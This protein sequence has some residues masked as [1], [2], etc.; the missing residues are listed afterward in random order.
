MTGAPSAPTSVR[1]ALRAGQRVGPYTIGHPLGEG[2]SGIVYRAERADGSPSPVAL[3]VIHRHLVRDPQV[4]RRFHR[5]AQILGQLRGPNLAALLDTGEAEDGRLYMALELVEGEPLDV[6]TRQGPLPIEQAVDIALQI[7]SALELAHEH[8]VVH[9]DLKPG[10]VMLSRDAN[11]ELNVR[12]LDFGMAKLLRVEAS[13]TLTAL[14]EA[15][16]VFGTPEYMAP[17]QARGEDVDARCDVYALGVLLYELL[18]GHVPFSASTPIGVMTAHLVQ[19][20]TPP[21]SRTTAS[22]VPPALEAVVLHALA[23]SPED[24]YP[25]AAA[26]AAALG[27]AR[28][29]PRNVAS[30]A[31]PPPD[32][33]GLRDT[34]LALQFA[35]TQRFSAVPSADVRATPGQRTWWVVAIVAALAGVLA[36]VAASLA[37]G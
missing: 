5:E 28:R 7:C 33:L 31:P 15:N 24:R 20:P 8:G 12:V 26:L 1:G 16:M 3:K 10:N 23:K 25:S 29:E 37:S 27:S 4:S 32:D 35:A 17:E 6:V 34:A 11:G 2:A 21:S 19:E 13:Q 14:T 30:T 22:P 36:G 18:T 9:R